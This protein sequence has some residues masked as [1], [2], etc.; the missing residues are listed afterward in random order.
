MTP[1]AA[2]PAGFARP[3]RDAARGFTYLGVMFIVAVLGMTAAL[4]G[5][6]WSFV[7]RRERESELMY[8]GRE[9]RLAIERYR[10]D[11]AGQPQPYPSRLEQLLG[12]REG[13]VVKRYLRRLYP[14]PIDTGL[15]WVLLTTPQGGIVG[16]H[17]ASARAPL[18]RQA[19]YADETIDF[20]AAKSYRDWVFSARSPAAAKDEAAGTAA[21]AASSATS[22]AASGAGTSVSAPS[23]A[24][25][26]STGTPAPPRSGGMAP[27]L[28][29]WDYGSQG[30]PPARWADAPRP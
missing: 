2:A 17:S 13:L 16:L 23:G 5:S 15:P 14:D 19:L 26:N 10:A 30:A 27:D 6:T 24:V 12:N 1:G 3:A 11:H 29:G 18:R 22:A 7:A 25:D 21:S 4:A 9:Y 28:P 8:I 20:A